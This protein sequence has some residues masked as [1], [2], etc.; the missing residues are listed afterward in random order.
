MSGVRSG[1][2]VEQLEQLL[3]RVQQELAFERRRE[4]TDPL[5]PRGGVRT[6]PTE[7]VA[8]V[9]QR[10]RA[11]VE[12]VKV[13]PLTIKRWALDQGLIDH[14]P[15]ARVNPSLVRAYEEAH[16]C[17]VVVDRSRA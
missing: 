11:E 15:R 8:A 6:N 3:E 9:V 5:D 12:P 2:R 1:S 16:G 17:T 4:Q 7:S 10:Q 14:I 13:L